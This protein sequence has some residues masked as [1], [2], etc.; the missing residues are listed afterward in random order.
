VAVQVNEKQIITC[1]A[2]GGTF[3]L[4]FKGET[5]ELIAYDA[6]VSEFVT[7]FQKLSTVYEAT[8]AI[9]ASY[10]GTNAKACTEAGNAITVEFLQNFGD[11]PLILP[12]GSALTHSS[13]IYEPLITSSVSVTGTKEDNDC[14][15]RGLCDTDAG[16]C[17]CS[18]LFSTSNGYAAA[19]Q[20]GDCGY[21]SSTITDCPG[22]ISCNG[23]GVCSGP[24]TY[25]C[26]C[27]QGYTGADCT[28]F[29]CPT[30]RSWFDDPTAANSA[31]Y[32][33]VECSGAGVC[34]REAGVCECMD[35]FEGAA[36]QLMAC[37][38]D[39]ACSDRGQCLSMQVRAS[40]TRAKRA[41]ASEASVKEDFAAAAHPNRAQTT[42]SR[43]RPTPTERA[44]AQ[45]KTSRLRPTPTERDAWGAGAK[46]F[47]REPSEGGRWRPCARPPQPAGTPA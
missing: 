18:T 36:C 29:V 19:G 4:E 30:G 39:P 43:L 20:R 12:D 8:S 26:A 3:T 27:E 7:A 16:T 14:S 33:D 38:G 47:T 1:A 34:D 24:P 21:S 10:T 25:T 37:P 35:G 23:Q 13:T 6:T 45:K 41:R 42:T 17:S 32:S 46:G 31:H 2:N 9:T 44:R 28:Q 15:D 5:T 40:A 11:L 22:E